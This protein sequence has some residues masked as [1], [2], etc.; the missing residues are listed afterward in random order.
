MGWLAKNIKSTKQK[1]VKFYNKCLQKWHCAPT[2]MT[3]TNNISDE[4]YEY[5]SRCL[6]VLAKNML[7]L[8]ME[9]INMNNEERIQKEQRTS[10]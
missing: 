5:G 4:R 6:K 7:T 8:V 2:W 10:C 3:K 9:I 1:L